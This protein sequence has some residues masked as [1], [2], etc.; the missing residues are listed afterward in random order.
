MA[1]SVATGLVIPTSESTTTTTFEALKA[2]A[3]V[4][5][6]G[7]T[8]PVNL[9]KAGKAINRIVRKMNLARSY[10]FNRVQSTDVPLVSGTATYAIPES[11]L[12]VDEVQLINTDGEVAATLD[13]YP[14]DGFNERVGLQNATGVP[15]WWTIYNRTR[16]G[17]ILLYATPDD[18]AAS[19]Y[20]LRMHTKYAISELS[21]STDQ[22]NGPAQLSEVLVT[23]AEFLMLY[24]RE[25]KNPAA[26]GSAERR[27][28]EA[29]HDLSRL[30]A[31]MAGEVVAFRVDFEE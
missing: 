29:M 11:A 10:N 14:W 7:E 1:V 5:V 2:E 4:A 15:R 22:L 20:T 31:N 19:D 27:F 8:D 26:W 3:C 17:Q 13:W 30:D 9:D 24:W 12:V 16:L 21:D 25:R 6:D 28:E 23:G 18:D